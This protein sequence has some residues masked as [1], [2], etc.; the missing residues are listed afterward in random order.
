MT[1]LHSSA[2]AWFFSTLNQLLR[3]PRAFLAN[4]TWMELKVERL[5]AFAFVCLCIGVGGQTVV[6]LSLAKYSM[7]TM[8][9]DPQTFAKLSELLSLPPGEAGFATIIERL[10][11]YRIE[12]WIT[13]VFLPISAYFTLYL[14]AGALWVMCRF[15]L[16]YKDTY[17]H[18][19]R[20]VAL[21]Q[22]PM[23]FA[24]IPVVGPLIS[25][26]L[27]IRLLSIALGTLHKSYGF[28]RVLAVITSQIMVKS[29]WAFAIGLLA[30]AYIAES[31]L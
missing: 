3:Q 2:I 16:L 14:L 12:K 31:K 1:Q 5:I 17:D 4:T 27:S 7:N 18:I 9:H 19:L 25:F 13:L 29:M 26:I 21:A 30:Q 11:A 23:I 24:V 10:S 20:A 6:E 15:S 28:Q 8:I 22:A